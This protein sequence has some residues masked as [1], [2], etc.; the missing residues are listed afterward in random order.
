MNA[1]HNVAVWKWLISHFDSSEF[2]LSYI[3]IITTGSGP[4]EE[5]EFD[6]YLQEVGI[7]VVGIGKSLETLV[8]GQEGWDAEELTN[9]IRRRCFFRI[10]SLW[11][12]LTTAKKC[13]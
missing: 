5:V 7:E 8:V 13:Y 11:M 9:L 6:D 3:Y 12:T 1:F 2:T 10:C 4:F